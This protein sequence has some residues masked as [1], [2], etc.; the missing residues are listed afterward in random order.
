MAANRRHPRHCV[1][2]QSIIHVDADKPKKVLTH[3][4]NSVKYVGADAEILRQHQS[5]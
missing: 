5:R 3:K 1:K 4:L 2:T